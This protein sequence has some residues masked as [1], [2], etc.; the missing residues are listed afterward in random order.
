MGAIWEATYNS[1]SIS[2]QF[3]HL[4]GWTQVALFNGQATKMRCKDVAQGK[5]QRRLWAAFLRWSDIAYS[6]ANGDGREVHNHCFS[7]H[8]LTGFRE[9]KRILVS[10]TIHMHVHVPQLQDFTDSAE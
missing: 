5:V 3:P 7:M 1:N 8:W 9:G 6:P 2:P 10:F 4:S